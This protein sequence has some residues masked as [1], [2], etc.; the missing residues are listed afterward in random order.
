MSG[1]G[2]ESGAVGFAR[3]VGDAVWS[4]PGVVGTVV[5][6]VGDVCG[7]GLRVLARPRASGARAVL[8]RVTIDQ[9]YF[10]GV[11][12][13][14]IVAG[15][16]TLVGVTTIGVGFRTL[17]VLGAEGSFGT[18]LDKLILVE[19]APL[20]TAVIVAAR[21]GSAVCTELLAMRLNDELD[22]LAA[23]G[24]DPWVYVGLPRLIGITVGTACLTTVFALATYAVTLVSTIPLGIALPPFLAS[25]AGAIEPQDVV[26]L[27]TKALLFGL[28]VA[29]TTMARGFRWGHD[30]SD[31]PRMATRGAMDALIT[32]FLID[33]VFA[34]LVR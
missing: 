32:I 11:E 23:H 20:L 14:P 17:T 9:I 33:A 28:A 31:L 1:R 22:A 6:L 27:W 12:A 5:L 19:L 2:G 18:V 25:L 29:A 7:R 13:V 8:L 21:S 3:S 34:V 4:T 10:T 15:L 16:A 24:V 26:L 30:S